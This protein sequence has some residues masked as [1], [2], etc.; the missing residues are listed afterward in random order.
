[1]NLIYYTYDKH[2]FKRRTRILGKR[3]GAL[4]PLTPTSSS[5]RDLVNSIIG[6]L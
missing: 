5:V 4:I 2:V 6:I 1:M 3:L